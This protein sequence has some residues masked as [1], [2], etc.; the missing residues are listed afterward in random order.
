MEKGVALMAHV[1]ETRIQARHE[2]AHARII[3]VA[4]I[5]ACLLLLLLV[6]HEAFVLGEGNSNLLG[7]NIYNYFT[8]HEID[9]LIFRG[10]V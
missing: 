5:E 1:D 7:L 9:C 4:D 3:N 6:F 10:F 8:G 2:L